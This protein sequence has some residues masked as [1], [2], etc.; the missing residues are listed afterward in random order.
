MTI[1]SLSLRCFFCRSTKIIN[2]TKFRN[3]LLSGYDVL[4]AYHLELSF[5]IIAIRQAFHKF[6]KQIS[7]R[8]ISVNIFQSNTLNVK[9]WLFSVSIQLYS[10]LLSKLR[11][12]SYL[13]DFCQFHKINTCPSIITGETLRS[14]SLYTPS[15]FSSAPHTKC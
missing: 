7:T 2:V 15:H 13:L 9:G 14:F 5:G 6:G 12:E 1:F 10:I 4:A 3:H 11:N 8:T